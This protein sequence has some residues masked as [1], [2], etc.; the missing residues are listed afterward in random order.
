MTSKISVE[1]KTVASLLEEFKKEMTNL[2]ALLNKVSTQT[3]E[4]KEYWEGNASDETLSR[5]ESYKTTFDSIREQN[6]KYA[7][8]VNSIIE[9]YTDIDKDEKEFVDSNVTAFETDYYGRQ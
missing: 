7:D 9:K 2:D 1:T 5:I 8:F 4:I 3:S 6:V